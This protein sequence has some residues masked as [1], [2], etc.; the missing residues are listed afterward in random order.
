M[1]H[2]EWAARFRAGGFL[3][4]LGRLTGIP[5]MLAVLCLAF[6]LGASAQVR[7]HYDELGRLVGAVAPDG[8]SVQYEYDGAGNIT[9]VRRRAA[10]VLSLVEFTPNGGPAG[11]SVTIHG[12]GFSATPTAN[13]VKFNGVDAVVSAAT[14]TSLSVTVPSGATTGKL[15][16]A[17]G[18][19]TVTS[20]ADFV[21]SA[22]LGSPSIT[23][24]APQIGVVGTAV[25]IS[26]TNFQ[27]TLSGNKASIGGIT[28][29]VV[30][31]AGNPT[32]TQLKVSVGGATAS[33]KVT[34]STPY[35][36]AV[37]VADFY[38]LPSTVN[39]ADV[40]FMGR[41]SV[42]GPALNVATTVAGKK[43]VVI[44]DG[45]ADQNLH[46][47]T[48]AGSF[49]S[50]IAV[51]VY[52]AGG[53]LLETSSLA[54]AG[55]VDFLNRLPAGG[56]YTVVLSP[57]ATDKG[58]VSLRLMADVT[59]TLTMDGSTPVNLSAGQNGRYS[60]T[61]EA[62]KGYGLALTGLAFTPT[63]G[64][65]SA[66]LRKA[67]GTYL[68]QCSFS[69]SNSCDFAPSYFAAAGTYLLDFDPSGTYAAS[70]NAVLSADAGGPLTV[71]AAT[72]ATVTIA[73]EGQN[74]RY[75]FSG[76]A[77]QLVSV[78]FTGNTLD[79]GNGSTNNYTYVYLYK[80]SAPN[81][82]AV[83]SASL[84]TSTASG[85]F[86]MSLPETGTYFLSVNPS[87]LDK[88]TLGLQVKTYA[89]GTLT[90]DGSTPVNL[91]AG[92]NGRYSFTAEANKGYGL[93]L[94][95]LAFTPTG[96]SLTATLRKADG[97]YLAQCSFSNS[98]SCD[99][100]PSY[101]AAAGTYLLDFDPSGTYAASFNAVLS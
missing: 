30:Q 48:S 11:T 90:M 63:G 4:R 88:G 14:T 79:D 47:V 33:G 18:N 64:S 65:L 96:G 17:N 73:R 74:A 25:T 72:P 44:F 22:G 24:F 83:G 56:T 101:F 34:V 6:P 39:P 81:S 1:S 43:A 52:R 37:S 20:A 26:G 5:L 71:D 35:G 49:A 80:P 91:S 98:N 10:N 58:A 8:S 89:S 29:P 86:D 41:V 99:L 50:S 84:Y 21:V 87:A 67:D 31:E 76:T 61:A 60:F 23:S 2:R 46:W 45:V 28:S 66:T 94:M 85:T 27:P 77:G 68:A 69:N 54:N 95:G 16:V 55:V 92:R 32:A 62:N 51:Q 13:T 19:G 75:T 93:A 78:V 38:A 7:Y 42:G 53:V 12:S 36:R 59:G 100:A 57:G 70:F 15:S 82:S 9:A 3:R 97:T 40:E